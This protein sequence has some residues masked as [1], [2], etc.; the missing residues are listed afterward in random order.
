MPDT[1]Q[2]HRTVSFYG[3]ASAVAAAYPLTAAGNWSRSIAI[4]QWIFIAFYIADFASLRCV[5]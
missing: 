5:V 4:A 2:L 1:R 3:S